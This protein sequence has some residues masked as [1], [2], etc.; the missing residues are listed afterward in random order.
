GDVG[1]VEKQ[2]H[3]VEPGAVHLRL[4]GEIQHRVEVDGRLG[5]GTA[6]ADETR[7]HRVVKLRKLIGGA[8]DDGE[9]ASLRIRTATRQGK[10]PVPDAGPVAS[11]VLTLGRVGLGGVEKVVDSKWMTPALE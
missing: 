3:A 8:H 6:L 7:P 9:C 1:V 11:K 5:A 10:V 4:R 2:V